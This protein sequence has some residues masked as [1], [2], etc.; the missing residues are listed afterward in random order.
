MP[1]GS[2]AD[3]TGGLL[4]AP[5]RLDIDRCQHKFPATSPRR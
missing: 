4:N 5:L 3:T 2:G 1:K